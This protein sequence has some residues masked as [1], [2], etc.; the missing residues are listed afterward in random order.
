MTTTDDQRAGAVIF[1]PCINCGYD[2]PALKQWF[3]GPQHGWMRE[4]PGCKRCTGQRLFPADADSSWNDMNRRASD[5]REG[6]VVSEEA[7]QLAKLRAE[8][9]ED[10]ATLRNF[11]QKETGRLGMIVNPIGGVIAAYLMLRDDRDQLRDKPA[12][13]AGG[14]EDA[15]RWC[16]EEAA[17]IADKFP[18][19]V[20]PAIIEAAINMRF[21]HDRKPPEP[22]T[23]EGQ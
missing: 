12:G 5:K 6:E 18:E 9:D 13:E 3:P 22:K 21:P 11:L 10:H 20:G 15:M 17:R 7:H 14:W 4:C 19:E 23:G 2:H 8:L 1:L 16:R